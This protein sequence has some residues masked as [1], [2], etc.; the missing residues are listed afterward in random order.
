MR[1]LPVSM[2]SG[3]LLAALCITR[4]SAVIIFTA[5][6][7]KKVV[8]GSDGRFTCTIYAKNLSPPEN[9]KIRL[10]TGENV[11]RAGYEIA[12][13]LPAY[14]MNGP[15]IGRVHPVPDAAGS[16]GDLTPWQKNEVRSIVVTGNLADGKKPG[17]IRIV[18]DWPDENGILMSSE[19]TVTLLPAGAR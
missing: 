17:S 9:Y 11:R 18:V 12:S 13:T 19:L 10:V 6:S 16:A 14:E 2:L 7:P 8:C 5:D 3:V 1:K 15:R 4:A